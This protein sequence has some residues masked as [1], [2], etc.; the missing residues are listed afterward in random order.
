MKKKLYVFLC[1]A[2]LFLGSCSDMAPIPE[3]KYDL[4]AGFNYQEY[5]NINKDVA[6]SQIVFDLIEKNK[7]YKQDGETQ[8]DSIGKAVSNCINLLKNNE[9][10]KKIYLEYVFCPEQ[11]WFIGD[12]ITGMGACWNGGWNQISDKDEECSRNPVAEGC[13]TPYSAPKTLESFLIDSLPK[14]SGTPR[15]NV[16]ADTTIKMMCMFVPKAENSTEAENYLKGFYSSSNGKITDYGPK[17]DSVLVM[18]HYFLVGRYDGRPYKY[19]KPEDNIGEEKTQELADKRGNYYDYGKYT[20]CL[21]NN[22]KIY[23]IK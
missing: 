18:Q 19:C 14:Y 1:V 7:A 11:G 20:F 23:V 13:G 4:P 15:R 3:E 9:F 22:K 5:A 16:K 17:F 10:A 2:V 12:N 6:M 8:A 21:D